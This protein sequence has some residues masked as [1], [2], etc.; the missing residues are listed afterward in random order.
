MTGSCLVIDDSPANLALV[1]D[2]FHAQ[3][4]W[5]HV[6]TATTAAE[7]GQ[8]AGMCQPGIALLGASLHDAN[9]YDFCRELRGGLPGPKPAILIVTPGVVTASE[10]LHAFEA[11]AFGVIA[12]P[13]NRGE[14]TGQ[15]HQI[16]RLQGAGG[17]EA[18]N[19]N[20]EILR[21]RWLFDYSPDPVLLLDSSLNVLSSNPACCALLGLS[22]RDLTGSALTSLCAPAERVEVERQLWNMA[23]GE[24]DSLNEFPF[25]SAERSFSLELVVASCVYRENTA[26][27]VVHLRDASR[28]QGVAAAL[29]E[30]QIRADA[31]LNTVVDA[32]ITIDERGVIETFNQAAS[33]IFGYEPA[34]IIGQSINRLMPEPDRSRHDVYMNRYLRT[35]KRHIIGIGREV[36]AQRRDGSLFP[37]EIAVSEL[38]VGE[39]RLFTGIV[40]DI[41]ERKRAEAERSRLA[42]VIEQTTEA[43]VITTPEG[44]I[45]Y[46]NPAFERTTGYSRAEAIGKNP[47][48]LNSG[49]QAREMFIELW[50]TVLGGKVWRGHLVNR[51]KDGSLFDVLQVIG[52]ITDEHGRVVNLVSL[53]QDITR[54]RQLEEQVRQSQKMEG[55][56]R[57]ASGIVHDF[58]NVLAAILG[59]VEVLR[60]HCGG[61]KITRELIAEIQAN[62]DRGAKLT[63]QLLTF[64]R[65]HNVEVKP[66]GLNEA[67]RNMEKLLRRS[68]GD[69]IELVTLLSPNL[70]MILADFGQMEQIVMNL[71]INARDAMPSGGR[72]TIQTYGFKVS[73]EFARSRVGVQNGEHA[74]LTIRDNGI[75]MAADVLD[76]IFEPFFTTKAPGSGTG[77]GLAVVYGIVKQHQGWIEVDSQPGHGTEFRVFLPCT[78]QTGEPAAKRISTITHK[79]RE[80]I[81]LVEDDDNV[82]NATRLMLESLGYRVIPAAGGDEA[83]QLAH[84]HNGAVDLVITDVMMPQMVGPA[85]IEKLRTV[86]PNRFHVLYITGF[87]TLPECGND[88][89]SA[90]LMKPFDRNSLGAE[91][92][93]LI[94]S[95]RGR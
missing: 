1:E 38:H 55:M 12:A 84:N 8:L 37:A 72:L 83:I 75:G 20:E 66:V 45:T 24:G 69:D 27:L 2:V 10:R 91:V 70:G 94:E 54:E 29:R 33:R 78:D 71:A 6:I 21:F 73:P 23:A 53:W 41:T 13:M 64:C 60:D 34:E 14:L 17:H 51:R 79:G 90:V 3:W 46:V 26:L 58:N 77:L 40:R 52:P 47:R 68:I 43:V 35:G 74:V 86:L 81:L 36:V 76:R 57:L 85:L 18:D 19:G 63:R 95:V 61:E 44:I 93:R 42:A 15:L 31:V 48:I 30:S 5:V 9:A 62:A 59:F 4:P 80:T 39:R 89:D 92:R 65:R 16:L 82:R 7:G 25:Q 49:R 87:N 11:G 32:I 56:G 28:R 50:G 67:V 22:P 88:P